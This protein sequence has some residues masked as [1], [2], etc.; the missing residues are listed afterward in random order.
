MNDF[1]VLIYDTDN[2]RVIHNFKKPNA[3]IH[4]FLDEFVY[5]LRG[6]SFS[7]EVIKDGLRV[8]LEFLEEKDNA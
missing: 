2:S 1:L 5:F 6:I 8:Q 7:D 4:N 3:D